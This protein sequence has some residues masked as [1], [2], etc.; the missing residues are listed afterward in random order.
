MIYTEELLNSKKS[1]NRKD[2]SFWMSK[3]LGIPK[4]EASI[5]IKVATMAI[6]DGLV[7]GKKICLS[8][9]GTFSPSKRKTFKG[10]HPQ[11]GAPLTNG[12]LVIATFKIGK[13]LKHALN[14]HL[15]NKDE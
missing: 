3:E 1:W 10:T 9:F 6:E 15:D 4:T 7:K 11:T 5:Y 12:P 2:L 8:D 13:K 14:P